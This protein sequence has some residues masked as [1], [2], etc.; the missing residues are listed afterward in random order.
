MKF[1]AN[2]F[3]QSKLLKLG[4]KFRIVAH[5]Y[6][7]PLQT[8]SK[9][10]IVRMWLYIQKRRQNERVC[11]TCTALEAASCQLH[12]CTKCRAKSLILQCTPQRPTVCCNSH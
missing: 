6:K 5:F 1:G 3:K 8:N 12:S 2:A 4:T 11:H 7:A 10:C 9:V